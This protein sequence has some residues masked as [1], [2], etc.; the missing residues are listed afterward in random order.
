MTYEEIMKAHILLENDEGQKVD[1]LIDLNLSAA[2]NSKHF[3]TSRAK[4]MQKEEKTRQATEQALKKAKQSAIS[5]IKN[6]KLQSKKKQAMIAR[7]QFWFEKFFWFISSENYLIISARDAHQNEIIIKRYMGKHDI[8]FHAHIQGSAFTIVKNP[9]DAPIPPVTIAEAAVASLAHSRAWDLKVATEVYWVHSNQV[10]KSAP[11]GLS[12]PHGS[13]MIYGKKNF[14]QPYKM[15][16]GFGILFKIDE[17]NVAA[18][19]NERRVRDINDAE[20]KQITRMDTLHSEFLESEKNLGEE[21]Q[22]TV[23]DKVVASSMTDVSEVKIEKKIK[24]GQQQKQTAKPK[25]KDDKKK[26][27]EEEKKPEVKEPEKKPGK[28]NTKIS[29]AKKQKI[30]NYLEKYGDESKEEE[31]MRLKIQGFKK[32]YLVEEGKKKFEWN[33]DKDN[34]EAELIVFED[35]VKQ[36]IKAEP[37]KEEIEEKKKEEKK[38]AKQPKEKDVDGFELE[39]LEPELENFANLTGQPLN[40]DVL[41]EALPVCAPYSTLIKYK[42]KV[43]LV[44]GSL[45][46]GKI[47]QASTQ[48][49]CTQSDAQE[50]L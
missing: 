18:H 12:L 29:K 22:S 50:V 48:L 49:F 4:L 11:S 23:L 41:Y 40:E 47:L 43:K 45:K 25:K 2:H 8:V 34:E 7:K 26:G 46:R 20:A 5:E 30:E 9:T 21:K 33:K 13:F 6:R 16:M 44:P 39:D 35:P 15:E 1:V 27:K 24:G 42:Y 38:I 10:S 28:Q 31:E 37:A 3:Y 36:D 32:N 19:T 14:I 17:E